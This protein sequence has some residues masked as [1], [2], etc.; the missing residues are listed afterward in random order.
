MA[1]KGEKY[2]WL[3]WTVTTSLTAFHYVSLAVTFALFLAG[4]IV[5][6][7]CL[8]EEFLQN[9]EEKDSKQERNH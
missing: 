6:S 5:S 3:L 8:M 2:F 1:E 7:K 9:H 4:L